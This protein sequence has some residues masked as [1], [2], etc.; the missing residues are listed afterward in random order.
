ML[1]LTSHI[2][3]LFSTKSSDSEILR[4]SIASVGGHLYLYVGLTLANGQTPLQALSHC[5]SF[6]VGQGRKKEKKVMDKIKP[7]RSYISC[8]HWQ[9]RL[10]WDKTDLILYQLK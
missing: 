2:A 1:L 3:A 5:P 6:S 7:G 8:H 9:N 4:S 10:S